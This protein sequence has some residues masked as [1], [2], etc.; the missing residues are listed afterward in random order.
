MRGA[1]GAEFTVSQ[2]QRPSAWQKAMPTW[3]PSAAMPWMR[4]DPSSAASAGRQRTTDSQV[5]IQRDET[6]DGAQNL[7]DILLGIADDVWPEDEL[8]S[9]PDEKKLA[10]RAQRIRNMAYKLKMLAGPT[11]DG[12]VR[13]IE[14]GRNGDPAKLVAQPFDVSHWIAQLAGVNAVPVAQQPD[15]TRCERCHR[16]L[17]AEKVAILDGTPYGPDCI[18]H[19]DLMGD[20]DGQPVRPAGPD[21]TERRC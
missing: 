10:R 8:P 16:T 5:Q 19:V 1:R 15:Y 17:S 20:A 14:Q 13:W 6:I 9:D 2:V 21:R 12:Y 3:T 11:P 7:T 4:S 18:H